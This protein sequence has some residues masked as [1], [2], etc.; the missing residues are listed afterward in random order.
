MSVFR[1]Q[2]D[3]IRECLCGHVFAF[4]PGNIDYGY[5]DDEGKEVKEESL[6]H[7]S[8]NRINC[9]KCHKIFCYNCKTL[10][11]HLGRTCE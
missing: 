1:A 5:K 2:D 8:L 6:I 11:Y 10:P 4:E 3:S 9:P 7:M